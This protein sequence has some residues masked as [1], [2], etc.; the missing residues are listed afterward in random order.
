MAAPVVGDAAFLRRQ[1]GRGRR[2]GWGFECHAPGLGRTVQAEAA[3]FR[4]QGRAAGIDLAGVVLA[5]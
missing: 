4:H 5:Q 2:G 1:D 3:G